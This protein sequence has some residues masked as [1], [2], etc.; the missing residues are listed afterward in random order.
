MAANVTFAPFNFYQTTG[1][2]VFPI[3]PGTT[4]FTG[5]Y[6]N[7]ELKLGAKD[8]YFW[9]INNDATVCAPEWDVRASGFVNSGYNLNS[10]ISGS[11]T[12]TFYGYPKNTGDF[13]TSFGAVFSGDKIMTGTFSGIVTGALI[14]GTIGTGYYSVSWGGVMAP[15]GDYH[16]I[17]LQPNGIVT[18]GYNLTGEYVVA[19]SALFIPSNR[20]DADISFEFSSI[21]FEAGPE[22]FN[23]DMQDEETLAFDFVTISWKEQFSP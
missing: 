3:F 12:G 15:E 19:L 8:G 16:Y 2:G 23:I 10:S 13:T 6:F 17:S 1:D 5:S 4:L 11:F 14:S 21:T 18:S 22:R 9:W 7:E 20:D